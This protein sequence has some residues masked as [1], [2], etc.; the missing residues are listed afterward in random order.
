[1]SKIRRVRSVRRSP[2]LPSRSLRAQT[3][4]GKAAGALGRQRAVAR[5][6]HNLPVVRCLP[7]PPAPSPSNCAKMK[8][9]L[10]NRYA[11]STFNTCPHQPLSAMTGPPMRSRVDPRTEPVPSDEAPPKHAS[12]LARRGCP[13]GGGWSGTWH[14]ASL[15]ACTAKHAGNMDAQHGSRIETG[16]FT[17]PNR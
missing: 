1:M 8:E 17:A 10:L 4:T 13:T 5:N 3:A 6:A 2:P 15:R 11:A 9:W 7:T 14:V 12:I 16:W